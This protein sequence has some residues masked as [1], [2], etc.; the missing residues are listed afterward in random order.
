MISQRWFQ[1]EGNNR[2]AYVSGHKEA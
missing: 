2:A 1:G